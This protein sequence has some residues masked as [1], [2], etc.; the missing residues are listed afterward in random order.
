MAEAKGDQ[1]QRT[2]AEERKRAVCR[3]EKVQAVVAGRVP[4]S[5]QALETQSQTHCC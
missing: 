1:G 3:E 4:E 2:K 5:C